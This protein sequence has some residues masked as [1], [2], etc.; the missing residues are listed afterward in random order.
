MSTPERTNICDFFDDRGKSLSSKEPQ[1]SGSD[2][3]GGKNRESEDAS[4]KLN[5]NEEDE[6]Q[7]AAALKRSP[8]RDNSGTTKRSKLNS[9][10]TRNANRKSTSRIY[11]EWRD[12][13][14]QN[15]N[16][17]CDDIVAK[18]DQLYEKYDFEH[19][20]SLKN[21]FFNK[22]ISEIC[23]RKVTD[24]GLFDAFVKLHGRKSRYAKPTD[25]IRKLFS[26]EDD[27]VKFDDKVV[28]NDSD[29]RKLLRGVSYVGMTFNAVVCYTALKFRPEYAEHRKI[30]KID[31]DASFLESNHAS[32][33]KTAV[34]KRKTASKES[35]NIHPRTNDDD[36][37]EII[38]TTLI[39]TEETPSVEVHGP[40]GSCHTIPYTADL[41]ASTNTR[42]VESLC[43]DIGEKIAEDSIQKLNEKHK[44]KEKQYLETI[45]GLE[46]RLAELEQNAEY[47]KKVVEEAQK[48]LQ[49]ITK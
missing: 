42:N 23:K 8:E 9:D 30:L 11:E 24:G 5:D 38:E 29:V 13:V 45:A 36:P 39:S 47:G 37:G 48:V 17:S 31:D 26:L 21:D 18:Y 3:S 7:T 15:S 22:I 46:Q 43:N 19:I 1:I 33:T 49:K 28:Q 32:I 20:K 40:D 35:S 6:A 10:I 4:E 2:H 12:Y 34:K 16:A 44:S 14:N 41:K 25:E 27:V